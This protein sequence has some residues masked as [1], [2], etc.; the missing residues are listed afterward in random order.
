MEHSTDQQLLQD[1]AERRS[2][3]AFTELV[4]RH[5]DLVH[6]AALRMVRDAHLAHDVTQSVFVALAR[7]ARQL[8]GRRALEGWLYGTTR[9]LAAN[10]V[11]AEVR[12][13]KHEQGA[14]LM[15]NVLS[16]GAEVNWDHIAPHLDEAMAELSEPERDALL[17]RYFKNQD[18]RTVG[19]ALGI[20]NDTAQKRV[21]RAVERL[22]EFF[23]RR[24]MAIG[25]GGLAA[26]ISAHAV[27]AA[28]A[29]LAASVL[30]TAVAGTAAAASSLVATTAQTLAMT[31][32]QKA[33]LTITIVGLA[34]AG[35]YEVRQAAK[36]REQNLTLQTQ[37]IEHIESLQRE[38]EDLARR[39]S[40]MADEIEA[41]R[42]GSTELLKL[43][44]EVTH[45][46]LLSNE[47]TRL[48]AGLSGTSSLDAQTAENVRKLRQFANENPRLRIPELDLLPDSKWTEIARN[49][50][51]PG[52]TDR[53]EIALA[54]LRMAA[55]GQFANQ[56]VAA[57]KRYAV[58]QNGAAPT[59]FG[60]LQPWFKETPNEDILQRYVLQPSEGSNLAPHRAALV[61]D[62]DLADAKYDE[63]ILIDANGWEFAPRTGRP[64]TD[65]AAALAVLAPVIRDYSAA[66]QGKEPTSPSQLLPFIKTAEQQV[67]LQQGL[68]KLNS[69]ANGK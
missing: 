6:S 32:L 49:R 52:R 67:A 58:A 47:L 42:G 31:A 66:N 41:A 20:S 61:V 13:R 62:R 3:T 27:Q 24:G 26:A 7:N 14:A 25:A 30:A 60:Q 59:D 36:W 10:T 46:R 55:R 39:L 53:F 9:N 63:H 28:P 50:L 45:L 40:A 69:S 4:R 43:R 56:I 37:H 19:A 16:T 1:Y 12:R 17:L 57:L 64:D 34:G 23:A 18:F 5:I 35:L 44:S 33:V 65:A 54:D 68:Q 11:R 29:G 22:R 15:S 51:K 2:E 48:Q 38:R 8:A 21:S